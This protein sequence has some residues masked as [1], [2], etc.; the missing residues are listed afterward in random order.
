[1]KI[2]F[3]RVIALWLISVGIALIAFKYNNQQSGYTEKE[4]VYLQFEN[5]LNPEKIK[6]KFPGI[7]PVNVT[8]PEMNPDDFPC[9]WWAINDMDES[10]KTDTCDVLEWEKLKNA[11][12][13][14]DSNVELILFRDALISITGQYEIVI[15]NYLGEY[16]INIK[17]FTEEDFKEYPHILTSISQLIKSGESRNMIG[18]EEWRSF[19]QKNLNTFKDG[20]CFWYKGSVYGPEF[21]SDVTVLSGEF[22]NLLIILKI[23]GVLFLLSGLLILSSIYKKKKGIAVNPQRITVL[24]DGIT[25]LFAV[26]SAYIIV[27]AILQKFFFISP[28][29]FEQELSFMGIFFFIFG[30]PFVA[31]FTSKLTSQSIIISKDGIMVDNISMKISITWDNINNIEFSNEYVLVGRVGTVIPKKL[32]KSLKICAKDKNHLLIN[33]PQLKSIK[34]KI[35]EQ[36]RI[37]APNNIWIKFGGILQKW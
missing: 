12:S 26:P 10:W 11:F 31:M 37:K 9:I 36:I 25:L 28:L 15:F 2:W 8:G 23:I 24:Y 5:Y 34:K 35:L 6:E 20:Q 14:T 16:N 32:Q 33:E 3:R 1:M 21:G 18:V 29:F 17:H 27:T 13:Q 19:V 7:E 4:V 22:P 30:I